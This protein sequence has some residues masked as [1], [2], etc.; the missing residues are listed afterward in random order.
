MTRKSRSKSPRLRRQTKTNEVD[1]TTDAP[2]RPKIEMRERPPAVA[3]PTILLSLI[4]TTCSLGIYADMCLRDGALYNWNHLTLV[5][6]SQN[7]LWKPSPKSILPALVASTLLTF[8]AF[9]HFTPMHDASHG[10]IA[11]TKSG[12]KWINGVIG[13]VSATFLMAI[14]APFKYLHIQHHRHTNDPHYDPDHYTTRGS[15]PI[16]LMKWFTIM[17]HYY[18]MYFPLLF[19]GER[20]RAETVEVLLSISVKLLVICGSVWT[21]YGKMLFLLWCAPATTALALLAF[22]FD[23]LPHRP[24]VSREKYRSTA[25]LKVTYDVLGIATLVLLYQNYHAVHHLWPW[26]PFYRYGAIYWEHQQELHRRGTPLRH[27]TPLFVGK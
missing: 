5:D 21:G 10:A 1:E 14:Y 12:C 27:L 17:G 7:L 25:I 24:G 20:N 3:W 22:S 26:I 11:T 8:L 13:R 19:R 6:L 15:P 18:K 16:L 23:Y 9:V 2:K 4:A